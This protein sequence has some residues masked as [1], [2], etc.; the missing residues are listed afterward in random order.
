MKK[1]LI[2]VCLFLITPVFAAQIKEEKS[3]DKIEYMNLEWWNNFND[4]ILNSHLVTLYEKN[5]DL[6]NA[7]LKIKEN[8]QMVKM[9]F[10][11]ELPAVNLSGQLARDFQ[12]PLQK[13]GNM[14]IPKYSQNNYN[15]PITAGYEID[16]WG[17]NRLYTK[18]KKEQ[19]EIVKQAERATYISLSSDFASDY[20]NLIK[21][22]KL[23]QIQ[24]ELIKLEEE[25]LQKTGE[26]YKAGL[27]SVDELLN[28]E[29]N[30]AMLKEERNIHLQTRD[31]LINGLKVY[32]SDLNSEVSRNSYE[33]VVLINDIPSKYE[34]LIIENRPDYLQEEANLKRIGFN[35]RAAKREFLPSFTIFGQIGLNAYQLSSLFKSPSQFFSAGI[36]PN[37]DL[38]AGGAKKALLKMRKYEYEQ[39]MNDYQKAYLTGIME[40]NSGLVE[41]K[42][43]LKNYD[44]TQNRLNTEAKLYSLIKDKEQIGAASNLE[45]LFAKQKYLMAQKEEV[46]NK[47]SSIMAAIGLYKATGGV[48]LYKMEKL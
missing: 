32:L 8:E 41:Y 9:Q 39:A 11:N 29:K 46:S 20:F 14:E 42:T 12:A 16:I 18:S 4:D 34:A 19:L 44:E 38:F 2:I 6:K 22:D 10:A 25:I 36:L 21:A 26:K 28:E 35:V 24:D 13:F 7:A 33:N 40:I 1:I 3:V 5:Y 30:L 43:S 17:K 37:F 48:N 47:I 23:I 31:V 15:I 45:T 27:C